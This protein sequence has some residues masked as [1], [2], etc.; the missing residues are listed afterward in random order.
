MILLISKKLSRVLGK[1]ERESTW[2]P[3]ARFS[4]CS[5]ILLQLCYSGGT[6]EKLF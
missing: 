2:W 1:I 4:P 3:C 6:D 5:Q